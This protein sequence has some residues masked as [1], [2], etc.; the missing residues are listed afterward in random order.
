MRDDTNHTRHTELSTPPLWW[1]KGEGPGNGEEQVD[2][3]GW[4]AF[5]PDVGI[6]SAF[7]GTTR[8]GIRPCW[9]LSAA[10]ISRT[11]RQKSSLLPE[12]PAP[13]GIRSPSAVGCSWQHWFTWGHLSSRAWGTE[14]L[15]CH[16]S[17][18]SLSHLGLS[19]AEGKPL[20]ALQSSPTPFLPPGWVT[21]PT[22]P[23]RCQPGSPQG[24]SWAGTRN[25]PPGA[26]WT[27]WSA[28]GWGKWHRTCPLSPHHLE[29]RK[30][31]WWC[32]LPQGPELSEQLRPN[33]PLWAVPPGDIPPMGGMTWSKSFILV[34]FQIF[35]IMVLSSS[36]ACS[37]L[38]GR[39]ASRTEQFIGRGTWMG[40][41]TKHGKTWPASARLW[42]V[43][44]S[45]LT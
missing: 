4:A 16:C 41:K 26:S 10:E 6:W 18:V 8:W 14:I 15:T 2:E 31:T 32:H 36:L 44:S 37:K 39:K 34:R 30:P 13:W 23:T 33:W 25:T 42:Q 11:V 12:P 17:S 1:G 7:A 3:P 28:L 35:L 27:S 38:P 22:A 9:A 5:V 29:G 40:V 19:W 43:L 45:L 24:S 20:P 21:P